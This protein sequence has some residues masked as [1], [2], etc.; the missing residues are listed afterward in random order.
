MC[1]VQYG[2]SIDNHPWNGN[3][4]RVQVREK[5]SVFKESKEELLL[6]HSILTKNQP[7]RTGTKSSGIQVNWQLSK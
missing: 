4:M 6:H 5:L 7:A 2:R 3:A 1:G